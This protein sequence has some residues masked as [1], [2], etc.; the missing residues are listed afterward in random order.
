MTYQ[1]EAMNF[2]KYRIY[3]YSILQKRFKYSLCFINFEVQ[4]TVISSQSQND[5]ILPDFSRF[6]S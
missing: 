5:S 3:I 6:N 1:K 4:V 2:I